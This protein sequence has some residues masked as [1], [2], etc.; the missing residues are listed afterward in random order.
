[1]HPWT[2]YFTLCVQQAPETPLTHPVRTTVVNMVLGLPAHRQVCLAY[3]IALLCSNPRA[4][5]GMQLPRIAMYIQP[6]G[7]LKCKHDGRTERY[8][9]SWKWGAHAPKAHMEGGG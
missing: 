9:E 2:V 5:A 8:R 6:T 7:V 4:R 3:G 1:V